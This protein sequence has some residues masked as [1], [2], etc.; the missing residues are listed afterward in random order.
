MSL[1]GGVSSVKIGNGGLVLIG[2]AALGVAYII[3]DHLSTPYDA[4]F[5]QAGTDYAIPPNLLRAIGRHESDFKP[6]A[7]DPPNGDYP[8]GTR[9]IGVMQ[10]NSATGERY[11]LTRTDLLDPVKNIR[12]AARY[13]AENRSALGD[14]FSV[15]TWAASYNVGPSLSNPRGSVY[16]AQVVYHWEL[17][18]LGR[19]FA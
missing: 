18:D 17:Y 13:L 1:E 6:N 9:D 12:A 4:A 16:A 19:L 15:Y 7:Y 8:S 11:G 10:V 2:V 3:K 5:D 14:R